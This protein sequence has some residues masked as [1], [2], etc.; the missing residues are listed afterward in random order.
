[1]KSKPSVARRLGGPLGVASAALVALAFTLA[2]SALAFL[3]AGAGWAVVLGAAL[4]LALGVLLVTVA[5][6]G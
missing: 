5:W 4:G 3:L 6:P 1:M 2:G